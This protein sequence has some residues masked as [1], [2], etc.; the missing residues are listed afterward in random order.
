MENKDCIDENWVMARK[1]R[2]H[3]F[4]PL[5]HCLSACGNPQ[6]Q[7]RIVHI[8][9]TNGK[10]STTN[11][12]KDILVSFGY[13]VGM[14]TSPFLECHF[15][16]I[17]INDTW[18]EKDLFLNYLQNDFDLIQEEN[19][20]MFE[21]DFLVAMEWFRD[22]NV[23]YVLVECGLGGRNDYTNVIDHPVLSII[24]TIAYD[25]MQVL[26]NRL[27]QIAFEKAG[28]IKH[29]VPVLYG[30]IH[31]SSERIV[32]RTAFRNQSPVFQ[33]IARSD[34]I[35]SFLYENERYVLDNIAQYQKQNASIA[36]CAARYLGMNVHQES[37][38]N[39][40][41]KSQWKGRFE[42]IREDPVII[43]DGAHNEEGIH[44]LCDTI[45]RSGK[46]VI[47]VFSALKDKPARSMA[48]TLQ[49]VSKQLIITHFENSRSDTVDHMKV[50]NA[51]IID[52]Y[53][54]A[55]Q[56]AMKLAGKDEWI[57]ISGSLYFVSVIRDYIRTLTCKNNVK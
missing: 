56:M 35:N 54:D 45:K 33:V 20:S 22:E 32:Q 8:A 13:R 27:E 5:I 36:L 40:I 50:E 1:N 42:R 48:Y 25:H 43:V 17:R 52:D 30:D 9:G 6:D 24:T 49:K 14:F 31:G 57:I 41:T 46:Q 10:G 18:I 16:R 51:V 47:V 38:K 19:L 55:I 12:L 37:V 53:Q 3:G 39:A 11:Y 26:G 23:D 2:K 21:I 29:R 15:D 44:A 4:E 34:G 7:L 28:I